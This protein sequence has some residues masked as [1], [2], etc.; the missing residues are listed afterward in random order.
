[1]VI[2]SLATLSAIRYKYLTQQVGLPDWFIGLVLLPQMLCYNA[3]F[4]LSKNK[5]L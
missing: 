5:Y 1:M 4:P 2:I 3:T